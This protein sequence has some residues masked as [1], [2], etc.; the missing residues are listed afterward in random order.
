MLNSDS[1]SY[2]SSNSSYFNAEYDYEVEI[3]VEAT[4]NENNVVEDVADA[5]SICC[6]CHMFTAE[7]DRRRL[8]FAGFGIKTTFNI[9][10]LWLN[11]VDRL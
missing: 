7:S 10:K 5:D 11:L 6:I 9:R 8:R 4:E 3:V 1:E 2:S